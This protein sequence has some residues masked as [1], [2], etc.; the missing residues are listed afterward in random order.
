M[1]LIVGVAFA[2]VQHVTP[3][4]VNYNYFKEAKDCEKKTYKEK[5]IIE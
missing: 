3:K 2:I 1:K 5:L 4:V